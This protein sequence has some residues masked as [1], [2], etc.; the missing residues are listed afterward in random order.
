VLAELRKPGEAFSGETV[1]GTV[2]GKESVCRFLDR[3]LRGWGLV[4]ASPNNNAVENISLELPSSR[5]LGDDGAEFS[6]LRPIANRYHS[7]RFEQREG[8]RRAGSRDQSD[9]RS[10]VGDARIALKREVTS[11]ELNGARS[12]LF[13]AALALQEA[14]VRE[15][16][17]LE[18]ELMALS[19]LML[20]PES[21]AP[22]I[23][24]PLWELLF[25]IIPA[26]STTLA[27]VERMFSPLS[28]G[29]LGF[30]V[31]DEAG[32]ASP[33]SVVGLLMRAKKGLLIGDQRQ[34]QPVV[35]IPEPLVAHFGDAVPNALVSR[36]SPLSSSALSLAD[37]SARYGTMLADGFPPPLWLGIPLCVHRRCASPMF[38]L[39]NEIAYN[40]FMIQA[41]PREESHP[42]LGPSGWFQVAGPA[43]KKQWVPAQGLVVAELLTLVFGG[44]PWARYDEDTEGASARDLLIISPFR[45]VAHELIGLVSRVGKQL[46]LSQSELKMLRSRVGT[47]HTMQGKEAAMVV[48]VLGCDA[49][50][51]GAASWAGESPQLLNVAITRARN[52]VY[53]IGDQDVWHNKG[54]FR[55]YR[56]VCRCGFCDR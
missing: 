7:L 27:S 31:I 28:A 46:G 21:C 13:G 43:T 45:A 11:P 17:L 15:V 48:L 47:I 9:A 51:A 42:I 35:T 39:S 53:V 49:T 50:T 34:L 52:L 41:Q 24:E 55:I 5:S 32:Q 4:L 38:D 16:P 26:I 2:S 19:R 12:A 54:F 36:V 3:R 44:N 8:A 23:A 30:V 33:Q 40:G 22:S 10:G 25:M 37:R 1:T 20:T 14:W 18:R 29:S 6:F 56:N